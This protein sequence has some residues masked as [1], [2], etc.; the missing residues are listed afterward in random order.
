MSESP[1][2]KVPRKLHAITTIWKS[3]MRI[4]K[5]S[6][7]I[8]EFFSNTLRSYK[9]F[10]QH[11]S[12]SPNN[13]IGKKYVLFSLAFQ[14]EESTSPRANIFV[15]QRLAI[16]AL[17]IAIPNDWLIRVREHPDQYGRRRPRS[18]EFWKEI[19]QI[20]K[21]VREPLSKSAVE[22]L[23]NA[24]AVAGPPGTMCVEAWLQGIPIIL[25]GSLF[26]AKAP[27]VFLIEKFSD[28]EYA[29][30]AV[31]SNFD[32]DSNAVA[33][34]CSWLNSHSYIG[35]IS[36]ESCKDQKLKDLTVDNME[37]ILTSWMS[38]NGD[39]FV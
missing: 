3:F 34:Y 22:S 25:F 6:L 8:F 35:N 12:V 31:T 29:M 2:V 26:L 4:P 5:T 15:E 33:G 17:S 23:A 9:Q 39:N 37:N 20:P 21:V 18:E 16:R 32:F 36:R 11:L 30:R 38:M 7:E 28:L 13:E 27:G 10:S 19:E 1:T 24:E 14:P